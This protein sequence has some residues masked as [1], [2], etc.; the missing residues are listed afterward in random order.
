MESLFFLELVPYLG[1]DGTDSHLLSIHELHTEVLLPQ[2]LTERVEA[3]PPLQEITGVLDTLIA[4]CLPFSCCDPQFW[5][6]IV[7][8]KHS[9]VYFWNV[10]LFILLLAKLCVG[11]P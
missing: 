2:G 4:L 11:K 9:C 10:I 3:Q 1:T 7:N 5:L 6:F 8:L